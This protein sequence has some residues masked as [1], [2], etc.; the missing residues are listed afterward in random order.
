MKDI[1][2]TDILVVYFQLKR[3]S[4]NHMRA[5]V[6]NIAQSGGKYTPQYISETE[7]KNIISTGQKRGNGNK[8]NS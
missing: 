5:F 7:Y 2:N 6:R 4:E 1:D 3:G 8:N